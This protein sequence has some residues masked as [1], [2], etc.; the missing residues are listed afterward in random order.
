MFEGLNVL[1]PINLH[2]FSSNLLQKFGIIF[3]QMVIWY[4]ILEF[5]ITRNKKVCIYL[6][7]VIYVIIVITSTTTKTNAV[8]YVV[9]QA[10]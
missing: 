9:L 4:N 2:Y 10:F 5:V 1:L 6:K 8:K 7:T 3:S